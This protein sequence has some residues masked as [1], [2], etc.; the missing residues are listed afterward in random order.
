[1]PNAL[2][3]LTVSVLLSHVASIVCNPVQIPLTQRPAKHATHGKH[4]AVSSESDICTQVGTELSEDGGNAA[5]MVRPCSH[6][7]SFRAKIYKDGRHGAMHRRRSYVSCWVNCLLSFQETHSSNLSFKYWWRRLCSDTV[8]Q[9]LLS[10]CRFSG[11][12]TGGCG[13][14]YVRKRSTFSIIWWTSQRYPR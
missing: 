2:W 14:I 12:S 3:R 10:Q 11:R 1:M 6:S 9:W 7:T 8:C 4:A 5:D 13:P